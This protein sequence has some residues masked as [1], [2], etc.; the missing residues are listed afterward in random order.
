MNCLTI[1]Y[2]HYTYHKNTFVESISLIRVF[3]ITYYDSRDHADQTL[4]NVTEIIDNLITTSSKSRSVWF[5]WVNFWPWLLFT[6]IC[7]IYMLSTCV[8]ELEKFYKWYRLFSSTLLWT[9]TSMFLILPQL[10]YTYKI[11]WRRILETN[12][13][14]TI[15]E[16]FL[17]EKKHHILPYRFFKFHFKYHSIFLI[18]K[19]I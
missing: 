3:P 19:F 5:A 10:V 8:L 11:W 12:I 17:G 16:L 2:P 15:G 14:L 1:L 6:I 13:V 9:F 4:E 7:R 18:W